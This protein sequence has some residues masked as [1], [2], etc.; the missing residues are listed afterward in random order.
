MRNSS[1]SLTA[2]VFALFVA[3]CGQPTDPI[4]DNH[5]FNDLYGTWVWAGYEERT[6]ILKKSSELNDNQYGLIIRPGGKLIERKN[7]GF[8]GTPPITYANYE[9]EWKALSKNLLE[10]IVGYWGGTTSYQ[11]EIV[12]LS[13][14][15]LK[16][17][18]HH[19]D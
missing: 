10:I 19:D 4:E 14:D 13:S 6:T 3:S 8:C 17:V 11:M 1:F 15:E 9:G 16:I 7:A 12:S 5:T 18:Y 2:I